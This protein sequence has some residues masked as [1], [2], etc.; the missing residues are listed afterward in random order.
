MSFDQ[1]HTRSNIQR[2][3]KLKA[4]NTMTPKNQK[5]KNE[6]IPTMGRSS[7]KKIDEEKRKKTLADKN[8]HSLPSIR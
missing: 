3:N 5:E 4:K 1:T 8:T 2:E 7:K 6:T